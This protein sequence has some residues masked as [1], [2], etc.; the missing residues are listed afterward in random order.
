M[1][2]KEV[3]HNRMHESEFG[4]EIWHV[5]HSISIIPLRIYLDKDI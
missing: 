1:S 3:L 4:T 2:V 5:L